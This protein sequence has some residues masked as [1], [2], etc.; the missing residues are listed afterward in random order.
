M[1]QTAAHHEQ[2][3]DSG[4]AVRRRPA[5]GR[6]AH[7]HAS[8]DHAWATAGSPGSRGRPRSRGTRPRTTASRPR[9]DRSC[10][11]ASSPRCST[12]RWAARRWSVLDR[13][14]A[15]LTAD[16][17]VEFLRSSHPGELVA[18]GWVV[19]RTRRVVFARGRAARR[20]RRRARHQPVHAGRASR[21]GARRSLPAGRAGRR[22]AAGCA[23][24]TR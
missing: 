10:R 14:Q 12:P 13:D 16:L 1:R 23:G 7:R 18:R 4:R 21:R 17:R 22:A 8:V 11:A 15:F 6:D 3:D 5:D 20:R 9:S 24:L 2:C 19:R